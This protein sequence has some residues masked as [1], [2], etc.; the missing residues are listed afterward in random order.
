VDWAE[1]RISGRELLFQAGT[2][3]VLTVVGGAAA[4]AGVKALEHLGPKLHGWIDDLLKP[5]LADERGTWSLAD[6][7]SP[8][9]ARIRPR[10]LLDADGQR[11]WA[12][13]AY[14]SILTD[15]RDIDTISRAL[16]QVRRPDGTTGYSPE[17]IAAVKR[18]LM[19]EEHRIQHPETG[20]IEIRRFDPDE[21]VADAWIRLRAGRP[22]PEDLILVNHELAELRYLRDHPGATY[23]QAHRHANRLFDWERNVPEPTR[24]DFEA[25]WGDS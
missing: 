14:D 13:D 4:K 2:A 1:G 9:G 3:L 5:M 25:P 19:V 17:E 6:R 20:R 12:R 7:L 8:A 16:T 24:E 23:Q 18:H 15:D 10:D 11:R 22:L 21:D